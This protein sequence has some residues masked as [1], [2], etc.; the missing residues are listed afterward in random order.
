MSLRL[1]FLP[2]ALAVVIS[3]CDRRPE[4]VTLGIALGVSVR[5]AIRLAVDTINDAGGIRGVPLR[6]EG[7]D[8][9]HPGFSEPNTTLDWAE[10]LA[11]RAD[12]M[13][14]I[15]HNDS[16]AT[17]AAASLY[18]DR[19][20]PHVVTIATHPDITR[21]GPW[22]FRISI[23]DAMQ[24]RLLARHVVRDWKRR[25]IVV[26]YV[27]DDYGN[28][29][30]EH[31]QSEAEAL[32]AEILDQIFHRDKPSKDEQA[33]IEKA[34]AGWVTPGATRPDAIVLL[35]RPPAARP[36]LLARRD[37][38]L[39]IPVIGADNAALMLGYPGDYPL[40]EGVR[41]SSFFQPEEADDR[42]AP[43]LA[44]LEEISGAFP[45][46]DSAFAYDAVHLLAKAI[47]QGGF[48]RRGVRDALESFAVDGTPMD[49]IGGRYA[50]GLDH[51]AIRSLFIVER[52]DDA[53]RQVAVY[54]GTASEVDLTAGTPQ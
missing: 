6:I 52:V 22:T 15:G 9:N 44:R 11:D 10:F 47:E 2:V 29:L 17:L 30:A 49:G 23:D 50:L 31:F 43:V 19:G 25:R 34:I 48:S 5:P 53:V 33:M 41:F 42:S 4:H 13:G 35:N 18:N 16:T 46:Y 20:L 26:F 21:A 8:W 7:L 38:E 14:V 3:G 39:D 1:V 12:V 45:N 37:H 54:S 40:I 51:N 36:I 27:N 32:G 28:G 24:G